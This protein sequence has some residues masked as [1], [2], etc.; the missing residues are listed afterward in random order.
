MPTKPSFESI[1]LFD[2]TAVVGGC[3][4]KQQCPPCCPPCP[5]PQ[6]APAPSGGPE[7]STSVQI[8][9]YGA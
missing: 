1:Q 2:L 6:A 4:K 3:H 7:I 9:G 5:Q 8:S